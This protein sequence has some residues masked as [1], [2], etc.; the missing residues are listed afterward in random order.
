M[1]AVQQYAAL[2]DQSGTRLL[3]ACPRPDI[4]TTQILAKFIA[5]ARSHPQQ[6]DSP[7]AV[8]AFDAMRDAFPCVGKKT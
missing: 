1:S 7:A 8:V 3:D 6:L 2:A 5:Y 4:T